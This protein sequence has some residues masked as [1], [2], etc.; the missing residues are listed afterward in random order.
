MS[1]QPESS[2]VSQVAKGTLR[3]R[4]M[5]A[6]VA[7]ATAALLAYSKGHDPET[8]YAADGNF[9]N[10]NMN[11]SLNI[12][13]AAANTVRDI[14]TTT[15]DGGLRFYNA[16][17]LTV[18]PGGAAIQ[19][20]GA[21]SVLNGQAYIDSGAHNN[22]FIFLRTAGTGG[23][24]TERMHIDAAGNTTFSGDIAASGIKQ[25]IM[26][27]PLDPDNKYLYHAA[28]EAPEQFNV[29]CG[30]VT[31]DASG[32][33]IVKLPDYFEAINRDYRYQLT[34]IGGFAQAIVASKV[35]KN[36]FS[37]R[38]DKPN[39]E[40]SWQVTGI[41]N[42]ARAKA[43]PFIPERPKQGVEVGSRIH[44]EDFG[45]P[46][47]RGVRTRRSPEHIFRRG[48]GGGGPGNGNGG[49]GNGNGG[50]GR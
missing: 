40:V 22:A 37:I 45:L 13:L 5:M 46:E 28:I 17:S 4:G 48:S 1:G 23:T 27:H 35:Q 42:D 20:W 12:T 9:D 34:V 41:R 33:A 15:N 2:A 6:G 14:H 26:D 11:G 19:F 10:I 16:P 30:N 36:Q 39:V 47:D 50:P 21:G 43:K 7:A 29:Y 49:P 25:F 38:T 44:P 18:S 3:R 31:T 24:I 8:A 32:Q